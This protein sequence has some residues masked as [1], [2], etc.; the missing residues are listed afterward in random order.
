MIKVLSKVVYNLI[1]NLISE[2][3]TEHSEFKISRDEPQYS[4]NSGLEKSLEFLINDSLNILE[5]PDT[6]LLVHCGHCQG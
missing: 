1:L 6:Y 5:T 4:L 2:V 3:G